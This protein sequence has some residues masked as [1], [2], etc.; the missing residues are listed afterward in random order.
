MV[1]ILADDEPPH[2]HEDEAYHD[3][4]GE[5]DHEE[6]RDGKA[7]DGRAKNDEVRAGRDDGTENGARC[8]DGAGTALIVA[9]LLHH[10]EQEAAESRGFAD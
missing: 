9:H 1:A 6:L 7:A 3:T 8:N 2:D 4:G 5:A 10:G